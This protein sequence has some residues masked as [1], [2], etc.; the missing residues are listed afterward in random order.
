MFLLFFETI[1]HF[2]LEK[3]RW[4][5]TIFAIAWGTF[6][7]S[8]MIS[9]GEGFRYSFARALAKT[10]QNILIVTPGA[11]SKKG[12]WL[13]AGTFIDFN[14]QDLKNI[15]SIPNIVFISPQ[16]NFFT[17]IRYQLVSGVNEVLAV[18][19]VYKSISEVDIEKKGRFFEERDLQN[20]RQ[21]IVLG[22]VTAK[23]LFG[24]T[25]PVGKYVTISNRP[26]L[27]LGVAKRKSELV[28]V[29]EPADILNWIPYT[30]YELL[31]NPN[32][33]DSF[34]ISYGSHNKLMQTKNFIIKAIAS[35]RNISPKDQELVFFRDIAEQRSLIE[36][37]IVSMEFFLG[38]LGFITLTIAAIG[39]ANV[40]YASI[41]KSSSE[42]GIRKAVGATNLQI[43]LPY[44]FDSILSMLLGGA[45]GIGVTYFFLK[46]LTLIPLEGWLLNL[47]GEPQPELTPFAIAI[48]VASL[49]LVGFFSGY[50]PAL[51]AAQIDPAEALT[52]E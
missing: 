32:V 2:Y 15:E 48:V 47:I 45:F 35:Q 28:S 8:S 46:V 41:K 19:P 44:M 51:K 43:L 21:V 23:E 22:P 27:V 25:D 29:D 39:I 49:G 36:K 38:L 7:I 6:A 50:F 9:I 33:I 16:Y 11:I 13:P 1:R 37:F 40:M 30:T 3:I 5:L 14:K 4:S 20:Y 24:N 52:Y 42:I 18:A 17:E 34:A 31:S 10:G 26:F 12:Q